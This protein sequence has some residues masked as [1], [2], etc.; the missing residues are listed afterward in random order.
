MS[1]FRFATLLPVVFI[2]GC[3]SSTG[4]IPDGQ[5]AYR[6]MQTGDTGFTNSNT[7]TKKAYAEADAYCARQG[8][9]VET[10]KLESKQAR[11]MGGWPE[12]SLWFRC[13][14]LKKE[15]KAHQLKPESQSI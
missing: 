3:T 11:P 4:V 15:Q 10:L 8:K 13:V 6:V 5:N 7:L 2:V 1:K 9:I 12:A 14:G